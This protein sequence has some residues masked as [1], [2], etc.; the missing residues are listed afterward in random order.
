MTLRLTLLSAFSALALAAQDTP[1]SI[2][3]TQVLIGMDNKEIPNTG[4]DPK[5]PLTIGDV[6]VQALETLLDED[7]KSTGAE[8]F[9]MDEIA[10]KV[11]QNKKAVLTAEQISMIK[12]RIGKVYGPLIV[13]AAWRVLDPAEKGDKK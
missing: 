1:R 6:T 4:S 3:F 9:H 8:K 5:K 10:R 7:R 11:Y 13:G 12:D 2:D